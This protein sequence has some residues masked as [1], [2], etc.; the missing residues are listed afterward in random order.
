M[1]DNIPYIDIHSHLNFAAF[2]LDREEVLS[3]ALD[4]GVYSIQVGTQKDT[5]RSAVELARK[6]E[7]GVYAIVGVHPIHT[8]KSFHDVKELGEGNRELTSRGEAFDTNIYRTMA[9]H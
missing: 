3:R 7:E 8:G 9:Q 2:D 4:G 6:Y 1:R 5:S